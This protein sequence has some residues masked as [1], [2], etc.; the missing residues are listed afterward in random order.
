VNPVEHIW[1]LLKGVAAADRLV[2]SI[3]E[4][5]GAARRFFADL[6]PPGQAAQRCLISVPYF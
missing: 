4:L 6:A 1:G 5:A 3:E 2:G